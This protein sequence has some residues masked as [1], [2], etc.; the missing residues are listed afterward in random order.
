MLSTS[1]WHATCASH[2]STVSVLVNLWVQA[3]PSDDEKDT[4][5]M[6]SVMQ[7]VEEAA[8]GVLSQSELRVLKMNTR[9]EVRPLICQGVV[10]FA[11][12]QVSSCNSLEL[13]WHVPAV[14]SDLAA[15]QFREG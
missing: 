8:Q 4:P 3:E 7:R 1:L 10:S 13:R 15:Q 12:L 5:A 2:D 14:W 9:I 11:Y 6:R